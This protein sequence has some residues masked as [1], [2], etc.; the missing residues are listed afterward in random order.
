MECETVFQ[1]DGNIPL[2][3]T[4]ENGQVIGKNQTFDKNSCVVVQYHHRGLI[5][6]TEDAQDWQELEPTLTFEKR[7]TINRIIGPDDKQDVGAE[8]TSLLN[9]LPFYGD[10]VDQTH[11]RL[12]NLNNS[13]NDYRGI[14]FMKID[15]L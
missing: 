9:M 4:V 2:H 14:Q 6:K 13:I 8:K 15:A 3:L 11:N 12:V 10:F 7:G 5:I 1:T